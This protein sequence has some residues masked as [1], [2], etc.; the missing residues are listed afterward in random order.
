MRAVTV[1]GHN[2]N[3][4]SFAWVF[5]RTIPN[6][7]FFFHRNYIPSWGLTSTKSFHH[8][9]LDCALI[10]QFLHPI[11]AMSSSNSLHHLNFG[12]PLLLSQFPL[13][14]V[15]RTFFVGSLSSNLIT[16]PAQLSTK[17]TE[18][19]ITFIMKLRNITAF[20]PPSTSI[21][22]YW[23]KYIPKNFPVRGLKKTLT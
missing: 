22:N 12:L 20:A 10:L 8:S 23:A 16:C 3:P 18:F 5:S 9:C 7:H 17:L 2:R 11:R 13:G 1:D 14:L 19:H 4:T 15:Q 21:F 6:C